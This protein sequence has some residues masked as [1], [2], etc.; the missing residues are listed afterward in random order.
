MTMKIQN[1]VV[2]SVA[3]VGKITF[4]CHQIGKTIRIQTGLEIVLGTGTLL[5]IDSKTR[6]RC[7]RQKSNKHCEY[8]GYDSQS[9]MEYC[10]KM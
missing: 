8:C 4:D 6:N 3:T 10:W 1:I 9:H 7:F 2:L 5:D